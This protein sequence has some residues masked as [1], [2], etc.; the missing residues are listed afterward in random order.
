MNSP[1]N[2]KMHV[3]RAKMARV[4]D[5]GFSFTMFRIKIKVSFETHLNVN[6]FL[7]LKSGNVP[8]YFR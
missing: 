3:Y 1:Y 8:L 6:H 4:Y 2:L 7:E 5:N